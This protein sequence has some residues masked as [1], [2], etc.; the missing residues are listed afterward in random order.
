M[1]YTN[2]QLIALEVAL[3]KGERSV[4]FAD[5]TVVYRS[6]D[7]MLQAMREIK[8]GI[9]TTSNPPTPIIRTILATTT[10]GF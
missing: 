4:S 10:K 7:E 2:E 3:A 9:L 6:V 5:R 1:A 8:R